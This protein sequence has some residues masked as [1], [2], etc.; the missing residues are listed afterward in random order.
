MK[1]II[2]GVVLM[3]VLSI[4]TALSQYQITNSVIGSGGNTISNT[5]NSIVNTIGETFIGTSSNTANQNQIGFWYV[6]QQTTITDIEDEETIPTVF[7]LEQNYPNPFN[8]STIIKFAVP[9]R[10]NVLIKIY[11]IIGNEVLTLA[12][13]EME[14]GWYKKSFNAN[15]LASGVYLYRM[16]AGSYI[17]IKKMLLIK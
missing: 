10:S 5:S 7:K 14:A 3:F 2:I 17:M 8:P 12:N 4:S 15:G 11:D 1:N 9:E 16:Q 13:E 6:Y